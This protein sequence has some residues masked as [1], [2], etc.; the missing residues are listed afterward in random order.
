[1][2]WRPF[3]NS[4]LWSEAHNVSN[5]LALESKIGHLRSFV[6]Y[7]SH[8]SSAPFRCCITVQNIPLPSLDYS[9]KGFSFSIDDT[10]KHSVETSGLAVHELD[11]SKKRFMH[12]VTLSTPFVIN[13]YLPEAISL[14]IETSGIAR[15]VLLSEVCILKLD[16]SH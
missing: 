8:P 5:I 11:N 13:N 2:R 16:D 14:T 15:T 7:P 9:R 6:C 1:M 3:G 12:L 4:Y 10:D